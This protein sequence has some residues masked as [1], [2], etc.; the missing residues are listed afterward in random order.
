[1][2]SYEWSQHAGSTCFGLYSIWCRQP[3]KVITSEV[4]FV[5]H[6]EKPWDVP[7]FRNM[8]LAVV[9]GQEYHLALARTRAR[10]QARRVVKPDSLDFEK[11]S[12]QKC[13]LV[14]VFCFPG[15]FFITT[16][17]MNTIRLL[18]GLLHFFLNTQ[19]LVYIPMPGCCWLKELYWGSTT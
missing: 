7:S 8:L 6:M 19:N 17:C 9:P 12:T 15:G 13:R 5:F 3:L 18:L 1:M 14:Y 2:N 10:Q 4:R 11:S 16:N